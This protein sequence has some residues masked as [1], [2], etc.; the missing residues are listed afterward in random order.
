MFWTLAV[1]VWLA[2]CLVY[3]DIV[4]HALFAEH[5]RVVNGTN[6][7]NG[8]VEV[9]NSGK[10]KRVCSSD[11]DKTEADVVCQEINCGYQVTQTTPQYYGDSREELAVK[12]NCAGNESSVSQCSF[13]DSK[14]SCIDAT[15]FCQ[16]KSSVNLLYHVS[17]FSS[18]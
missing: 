14:D 10:W 16:S 1:Y 3:I 6:R 4:C 8:R 13:Q 17:W 7:C 15:I 11:W 5:L 2:R 9:Y 12:I 18:L